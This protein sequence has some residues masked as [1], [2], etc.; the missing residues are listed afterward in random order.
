M[1]TRL[2]VL[3]WALLALGGCCQEEAPPPATQAPPANEAPLATEAP[4]ATDAPKEPRTHEEGGLPPDPAAQ[5]DGD[6]AEGGAPGAV[7]PVD[8]EKTRY[9]VE[10]YDV[11]RNMTPEKLK[12]ALK[13]GDW[14]L[15]GEPVEAEGGKL[16]T[17]RRRAL[18]AVEPVEGGP[19]ARAA[20]E[21]VEVKVL[22]LEKPDAASANEYMLALEEEGVAMARA[23]NFFIVVRAQGEASREV[24]DDALKVVV[25][26][27]R[28]PIEA[29]DKEAGG[30]KEGAEEGAPAAP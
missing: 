23:D 28:V 21:E 7:E 22:F 10:P 15:V 18:E 25:P 17:L 19:P 4:T 29:G 24:A 27:R 3:S 5:V 1:W 11:I 30:K 16:L 13:D 8:L 2:L 14:S 6:P 26:L 9:E 20:S 12:G